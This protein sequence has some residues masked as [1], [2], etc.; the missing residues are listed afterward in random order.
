MPDTS[1]FPEAFTEQEIS[2]LERGFGLTDPSAHQIQR[3]V[4]TNTKDD[5][6]LFKD[7]DFTPELALDSEAKQF[8]QL[9]L[10]NSFKNLPAP[11]LIETDEYS[12]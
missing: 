1:N 3:P 10:Q 2:D 11:A 5:K 9:A 6:K 8:E 7:F 12:I 4:G